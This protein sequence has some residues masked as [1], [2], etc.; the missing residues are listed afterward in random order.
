LAWHIRHPENFTL[1]CEKALGGTHAVLRETES[2]YHAHNFA[3]S[4]VDRKA[5]YPEL[6]I[7]RSKHLI[8]NP[9][10]LFAAEDI[11]KQCS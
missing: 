10:M 8:E 2:Y 5:T 6:K 1:A 7:I 4:A 11:G 9:P 3:G